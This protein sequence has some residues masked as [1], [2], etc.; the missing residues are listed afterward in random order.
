MESYGH[1]EL[2]KRKSLEV[3]GP[4]WSVLRQ[5][6]QLTRH[7][8]QSW[9]HAVAVVRQ[10]SRIKGL[11]CGYCPSAADVPYVFAVSAAAK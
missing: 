6:T 7:N 1:D 4:R 5:L 11:K 9:T 3:R 8:C 10:S 2:L